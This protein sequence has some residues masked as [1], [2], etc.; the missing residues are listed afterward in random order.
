MRRQGLGRAAGARAVDHR[1]LLQGRR[2]RPAGATAGSPPATS[3]TIDADG[4]MQIT[5]RTKDVIKSGGEWIGSIDLENIAMAHPAVAMAAV[6]RRQA[7]E[8]GRA[9][10]AGGGEE[11]RRRADARASCSRSSRAR[12][13]SGGRPTTWCSSTP[14]RSAPPARCRRTSCASSSRTTSCRRLER[15]RPSCHGLA[16]SGHRLA[17]E[18][19]RTLFPGVLGLRRRRRGGDLPGRA[20]RRAGDAVRAAAGHGDELPVGRGAMPPGIEFTARA[21]CCA[22]AWRCS[23]LRITLGQ[24]AALGWQP[25]AHGRAVRWC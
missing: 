16:R 10:A 12:S 15:R 14:S 24:V 13:P 18:Q 6:H 9:A 11:A 25:V 8:V 21:R 23:G 2:R 3:R 7:P 17:R 22:S 4:Y 1:Q 20:L 5:D 19:A